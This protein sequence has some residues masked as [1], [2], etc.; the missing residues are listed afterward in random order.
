MGKSRGRVGRENRYRLKHLSVG[1]LVALESGRSNQAY[2][3]T[4]PANRLIKS[5]HFQHYP[6]HL[7]MPRIHDGTSMCKTQKGRPLLSALLMCVP[8]VISYYFT[9]TSFFVSTNLCPERSEGSPACSIRSLGSHRSRTSE[10]KT[11]RHQ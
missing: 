11:K 8:S 4:L 9:N 2:P 3:G 1:K 10:M 7:L 6:F 5:S